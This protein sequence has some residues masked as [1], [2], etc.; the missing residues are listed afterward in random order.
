MT[1]LVDELTGQGF[2]PQGRRRLEPQGTCTRQ[3]RHAGERARI[4][5]ICL[6]VA[7]VTPEA[8]VLSVLSLVALLLVQK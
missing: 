4:S 2:V 5:N 7:R 6:D 3:N 8:E 1:G